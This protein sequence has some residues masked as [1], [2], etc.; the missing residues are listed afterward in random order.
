MPSP[1]KV[2]AT[3]AAAPSRVTGLRAQQEMKRAQALARARAAANG[4]L[5]GHGLPGQDLR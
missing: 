5:A 4:Q 1:N 2:V 3:P